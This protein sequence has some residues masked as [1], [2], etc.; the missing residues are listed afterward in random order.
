MMKNYHS[1]NQLCNLLQLV[2]K[3]VLV[4]T[5][6]QYSNRAIILQMTSDIVLKIQFEY[7]RFIR[8]FADFGGIALVFQ[9]CG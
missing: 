7:C 2:L 8:K 6:S 9:T 1:G 4:E 3:N 5:K